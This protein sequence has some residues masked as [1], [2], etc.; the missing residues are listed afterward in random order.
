VSLAVSDILYGLTSA[1]VTTDSAGNVLSG[2]IATV[3]TSFSGA[4]VYSATKA[5][6]PGLVPGSTTGGLVTSDSMGR[7]AFFA[8]SSAGTLWLDFG[9]GDRWPVNPLNY[10]ARIAAEVEAGVAAATADTLS[11]VDRSKDAP[12]LGLYFPEAHGAVGDGVTDD[13][14]AIVAALDAAASGGGRVD[15]QKVHAISAPIVLPPNVILSGF[16]TLRA[17]ASMARMLD[18]G[19]KALTGVTLD[20]N[21]LV[22][23]GIVRV[24]TSSVAADGSRIRGVRLQDSRVALQGIVVSGSTDV[25]VDASLFVGCAT[26]VQVSG[27][28]A[29]I[30]VTGNQILEWSQRGIY[31]I[32]DASNKSSDV[33][34]A[35]NRI[36]D[37][38]PGGSSRYPI[39]V[40]GGDDDLFRHTDVQVLDN[41]VQGPGTSYNDP[42]VPGTADQLSFAR[43]RGLIVANNTS[44]D[45]GDA[46]MTIESQCEDVTVNGNLIKRSDSAGLYLGANSSTFVRRVACTGNTI[47]DAGQNR[48]GDRLTL[49]AINAGK[50]S[51]SAISGNVLGNSSGSTPT[52]YG[53]V[54]NNCSNV[55]VG[56]N[57]NASLGTAL[58]SVG[59]GNSGLMQAS[60]SALT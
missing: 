6:A 14:A 39:R 60:V 40:Q 33:L 50:L 51:Y 22:T 47:I 15:I 9:S 45:G 44:L 53:V 24:G 30:R 49:T 38:M 35:R 28:N 48:A 1:D 10:D 32:G 8:D 2:L 57:T 37:L 59:S 58:Y 5:V 46:G 21:G 13:R 16:G 7:I 41:F 56:P 25:E 19:G 43:V 36:T 55:T 18:F 27:T 4:T 23:S 52:Q 12:A 42:T 29:R 26:A 11:A 17:T 31:V 3:Y 34:I 20:A 54:F